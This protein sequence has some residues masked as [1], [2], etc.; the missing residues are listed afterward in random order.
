MNGMPQV[1]ENHQ[2]LHRLGGQWVGTE[3]MHPSPWGP[4]GTATGRSQIRVD[5]DGFFVLQDY[6]QERDGKI[7]YRDHG[8]FGWDDQQKNVIW[9]WVDSMGFVPPAPSR[10]QW[11]GDTLTLEHPPLAGS[12]GRYTF[13][14]VDD[15][16]Y[17][18][19]IEN[20]RDDGRSYQTFLEASYRRQ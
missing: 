5:V 18:F 1:N 10:G 16:R 6:V 4:G 14:L 19:K 2:R 7:A 17:E 15:D 8:I 3:T 12:R 20:S 13:R 9:Y 11:Q